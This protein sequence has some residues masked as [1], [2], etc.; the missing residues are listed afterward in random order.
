M[1]GILVAAGL[2]RFGAS[3]APTGLLPVH[4]KALMD[5]ALE[6]LLAAG[7]RRILIVAAPADAPSYQAHLGGGEKWGAWFSY[8]I[9]PAPAPASSCALAMAVALG[10]EFVGRRTVALAAADRVITGRGL[11]AQL[12]HAAQLKKGARVFVCD[13]AA[14]DS[15]A[16]S[17]AADSAADSAAVASVPVAAADSAAE[18]SPG[19]APGQ[20]YAGLFFYDSSA[21]ARMLEIARQSPAPAPPRLADL[22]RAYQTAGR[23]RVETLDRAVKSLRVTGPD[24]LRAAARA[25]AA[26]RRESPP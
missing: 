5:Y 23:L 8:L 12:K 14:A 22:H 1:R 3:D 7:I 13:G 17:T 25:V 26:A 2:P 18:P 16:D 9:A 21:A 11:D 6:A 24:S 15:S 4:D 19:L 20:T 10:G